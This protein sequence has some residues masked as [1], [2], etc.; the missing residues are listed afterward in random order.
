MRGIPG[1]RETR[2][3]GALLA[4]LL[5]AS[6]VIAAWHPAEAT[7]VTTMKRPP[8]FPTCEGGGHVA[9]PRSKPTITLLPTATGTIRSLPELGILERA[10]VADEIQSTYFR[11]TP[12]NREFRR[13]FVEF[14]VPEYP[15]RVLSAILVLPEGGGW[16]GAPQ[17][18][19]TH[20]LSYYPADL[21]VDVSDYDRPARP[22][23]CF[24]TDVNVA[25][26]RAAFDV[27]DLIRRYAGA[28]LGF[29]VRLLD[30]P[31]QTRMA[32]LGAD[33]QSP[34]SGDPVRIEI[35]TAR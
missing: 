12:E 32:A 20:T 8:P 35:T 27:T 33:F 26:E 25:G 21:S 22:V 5:I 6:F 30:D 13:G 2:A 23:G 7:V 4:A 28:G 29:R 11:T 18:A 9:L 10:P 17:P 34:Y 19:D 14:A 15:R 24:E 1:R 3:L 16:S 31:A